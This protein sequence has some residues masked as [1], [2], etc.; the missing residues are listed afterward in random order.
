MSSPADMSLPTL[1]LAVL[2]AALMGFAV[3]RGATCMVAAVEEWI[4]KRSA[5]RS[6]AIGEA[7]LW[8]LGGLALMQLGG[9]ARF[10]PHGFAVTGWTVLGGVLLGLGAAVNRACVFGAVDRFGNGEWAYALTPAGYF[11]GAALGAMTLPGW[12]PDAR[13]VALPGAAWLLR[14]EAATALVAVALGVG[15]WMLWRLVQPLWLPGDSAAPSGQRWLA[16]W[17]RSIWRPHEATLIIGVSFVLL[18]GLAGRWT[19]IELLGDGAHGQWHDTGRR[20]LLFVALG[21]GAA[22]GGWTAHRFSPQPWG[23]ALVARC[24]L[25][26]ALMGLGA[27]LVPG[28]NDG[29]ILLGLPLLWPHAWVAVAAMARSI[30]AWSGLRAFRPPGS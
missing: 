28:A 14:P 2:L 8:V 9:L 7:S 18:L 3:Q 26:G 16:R 15:L 29:L 23:A 25:G 4:S 19:Y 30:A 6:L 1:A 11:A 24:L 20:L 10:M 13:P 5:R 22:W 12:L 17:Q 21:A 27:E